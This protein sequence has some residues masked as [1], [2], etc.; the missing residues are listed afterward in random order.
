MEPEDFYSHSVSAYRLWGWVSAG[1]AVWFLIV[2]GPLTMRDGYTV[3]LDSVYSYIAR[4]CGMV[5]G[6]GS[7][8]SFGSEYMAAQNPKVGFYQ[9]F[10][11]VLFWAFVICIKVR[12]TLSIH[13]CIIPSTALNLPIPR[14]MA[15]HV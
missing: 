10:R 9:F 8:N 14:G 12:L 11:N 15:N 5:A 6:T 4:C 2:W 13:C 1:Y 3:T 7:R